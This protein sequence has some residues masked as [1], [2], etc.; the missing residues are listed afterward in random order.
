[1]EQREYIVLPGGTVS[2]IYHGGI[3]TA[4]R[5][6]V[7]GFISSKLTPLKIFRS[8]SDAEFHEEYDGGVKF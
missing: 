3:R 6:N 4:S 8:Y 5:Q 1:M 7:F 2:T